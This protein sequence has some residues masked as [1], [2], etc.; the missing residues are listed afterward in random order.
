[1]HVTVGDYILA[2]DGRPLKSGDNY[3]KFYNSVPGQKIEFTVNSKP[4][5]EGAWRTKVE[6][7]SG[8]VFT[9]MQYEKWVSDRRAMVDKLSGGKIAYVHI[10]SMDEP[11]LRRRIVS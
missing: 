11:S 5:A 7:V 10:R 2:V 3:W 8:Q 4:A 6:P 9:T 1:M